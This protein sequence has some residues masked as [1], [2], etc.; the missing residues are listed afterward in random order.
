MSLFT[1]ADLSHLVVEADVDETYAAQVKTGM[2]V[3]LQL[4]GETVTRP[5]HVSFVAPRVDADTGGLAIKMT[6]DSAPQMPVGLTVTANIIVDQ[7]SAALTAPRSAIVTDSA[8]SAVFLEKGGK[9]VRTAVA[10]IDWPA[11]RLI[12]TSGLAAGDRLIVTAAGLAD[13]QAVVVPGE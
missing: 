8:G 3:L 11:S 9:A 13:G 7:R 6:F 5:G 12:V 2:P 4:V 1:L 10:L